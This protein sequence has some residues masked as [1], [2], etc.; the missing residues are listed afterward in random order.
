MSGHIGLREDARAGHLLALR[1]AWLFRDGR[2]GQQTG[3]RVDSRRDEPEDLKDEKASCRS[4][5]RLAA[6]QRRTG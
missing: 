1:I 2:H 3:S 5:G 6:E 4:P